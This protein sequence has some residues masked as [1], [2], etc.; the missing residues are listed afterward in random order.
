LPNPDSSPSRLRRAFP[1]SLGIGLSLVLLLWALRG[2]SLAEVIHHLRE[3]EPGPLVGAVVIATLT[4]P[5]RLLRWRL[6]LRHECGRAYPSRPLWHAIA[7]GFMANNLLPLRAGELVRSYT[8][9]RLTGA[10]FTTVLSSVAVE[11]IFDALT[12]V[13]LLTFALL[14]PDLPSSVTVGDTSV[15]HLARAAGVVAAVGLLAAIAIV[16]APLT[17]ERVVR[18]LVRSNRVADRAVN[19]IEAVRQGLVVLR[20]PSR[21]MAVIFWSLVLWLVNALGFYIGFAAFHIPV[22]YVGALLMQGLLIVGISIPSTPGFFGPFEAVIV[23]ALALYGISNDVAFSYAIAF[24]VTS[25]IP[26]TLLGLW[27]LTRIPGGFRG[28]RRIAL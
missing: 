19:L 18:Q 7:L 28:L 26:V 13:A 27:S 1:A 2:V 12:V 5:L 8:A 16:A 21:L 17:A 6:L 10:R 20:T 11:R 14:S 24:H 9:S 22:S 15:A 4:F 25:F 23:A 3:A